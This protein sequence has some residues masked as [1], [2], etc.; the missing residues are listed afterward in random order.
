MDIQSE[1]NNMFDER[2]KMEQSILEK[3]KQEDYGELSI[4]TIEQRLVTTK[5]LKKLVND[6]FRE[7]RGEF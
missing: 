3:R 5:L 4:L 2:I 1:I 7:N 6:K